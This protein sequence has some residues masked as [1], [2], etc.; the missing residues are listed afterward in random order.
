MMEMCLAYMSEDDVKAMC[1]ANDLVWLIPSED[2]EPNPIKDAYEGGVCPDCGDEIPDDVAE[3][4]LCT[5]CAYVFHA[6]STP[7]NPMDD[8]NYVGHPSHY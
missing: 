3:G 4:D 5:N 2:D 8:I 7:D 6:D 1:L